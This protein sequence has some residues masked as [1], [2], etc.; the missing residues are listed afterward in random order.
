M[1]F[2][3]GCWTQ[4]APRHT[5]HWTVDTAV[6]TLQCILYTV[7]CAFFLHSRRVYWNLNLPM[8]GQ[9]RRSVVYD[10]PSPQG[11]V[12][13]GT[14]ERNPSYS[15]VRNDEIMSMCRKSLCVSCWIESL[16]KSHWQHPWG[17]QPLGYCPCDFPRDSIHHDTPSAFLHIVPLYTGNWP[18]YTAYYTLYTVHCTVYTV[19]R[20]LYTV[21]SPL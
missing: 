12:R 18:L 6:Y 9:L 11:E 2:N 15:F 16:R 1:T 3:T 7:Y 21:H 17:L 10:T 20:T 14:N 4:D 8:I 13:F 19:H 5:G